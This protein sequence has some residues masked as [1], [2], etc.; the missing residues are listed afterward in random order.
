MGY[1]H[2]ACQMVVSAINDFRLCVKRGVV[3]LTDTGIRYH[4][5][6]RQT[7]RLTKGGY[8]EFKVAGMTTRDEVTNLVEFI[9]SDN[10]PLLQALDIPI[11]GMA[12]ARQ[13][14]SHQNVEL[15]FAP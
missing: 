13:I 10:N 4:W 6:K 7:W 5:P 2:L 15:H 12:F 11:S 3:E 14:L 1:R 8:S 9:T